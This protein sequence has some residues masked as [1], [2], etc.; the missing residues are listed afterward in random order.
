LRELK[1]V[2]DEHFS[3]VAINDPTAEAF[4]G[5]AGIALLQES[6]EEWVLRL[7][8]EGVTGAHY[9][10]TLYTLWR[11]YLLRERLGPKFG[12]LVKVM[13]F[14]S[15]LR[16]AAGRESGPYR[17]DASHLAKFRATLFHR[18]AAAKLAGPLVPFRRV[19][20]MGRRLAARTERRSISSDER[21][22]REAHRKRVRENSDDHKLDREMPDID[23]EVIQKGFG[24]LSAMVREARPGEE[25]LLRQYV[26]E[27][28]ELQLRTLPRPDPED[29]RAEILRTPYQSDVWVMGRVA[30]FIAHANSVET[31]R[32]FYRPVLELGPAGKYWVEEFLQ[33]WIALGLQ[34]SPD[35]QGFA[36]IWQDMV[37]YSETLPAWQPGN[38]NYWSR[39][40]SL[41]VDLMG[42][43]KIGSP[44]LGDT[45]HQVVVTSMIPTFE[46]WCQPWLKYASVAA[47]FA[48]FL[49]TDSGR[50]LLP[51]GVKQLGA[52]IDTLPDRDWHHHE[53]GTLFTD[54]LS[55]CW[56]HLSS[57]VEKDADLREA[58][59][60]IL[61]VLCARQIP[62]ALHLRARVAEVLGVR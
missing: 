61:A 23:L 60:S 42:L 34:V 17:D 8:F 31:A 30:E 55:L 51:Q 62:E 54:V 48:N 6:D 13:V 12:E 41:A 10:S 40:E 49:R 9:S 14:W 27:L 20:L 46:R 33:S 5:E 32:G 57:D 38:G 39:A 18:Y 29:Q 52:V 7:A 11:A 37:A 15:A 25:A 22:Q 58:F 21:R 43:G 50:V 56:K 4:L 26:Q 35:L 53:L 2:M 3:P 44:V 16:Y 19:E 36:R 47:W 1:P 59:L 24:F 28:F 45:K